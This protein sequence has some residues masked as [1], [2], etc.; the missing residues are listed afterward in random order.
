MKATMVPVLVITVASF[1]WR[2]N[3]RGATLSGEHCRPAADKNFLLKIKLELV[4]FFLLRVTKP[5]HAIL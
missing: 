2:H 5:L 3:A 4:R 1:E